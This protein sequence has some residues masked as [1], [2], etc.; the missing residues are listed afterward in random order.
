[1]ETDY[2]LHN[3]HVKTGRG[4]MQSMKAYQVAFGV[5]DW[6]DDEDTNTVNDKDLAVSSHRQTLGRRHSR[7]ATLG[8]LDTAM[9]KQEDQ[10]VRIQKVRDRCEAQ[11]DSLSTWWKIAIQGNVQQRMWMQLGRSPGES[12]LPPRFERL[13]QPGKMAQFDRFF[14]R[15]WATPVRRSHAAQHNHDSDDEGEIAEFRRCISGRQTRAAGGGASIT[16]IEGTSGAKLDE[17]MSTLDEFVNDHG[18]APRSEPSMKMFLEHH[19]TQGPQINRSDTIL[20]GKCIT[21]WCFENFRQRKL[22]LHSQIQT[23]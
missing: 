22:S 10:T 14:A 6:E 9:L 18:F 13:Y 3:F 1:M 21:A 20:S 8:S 19:D 4:T 15:P 12:L 7:S 11:N 5:A 23:I 17:N 16:S 2:Y